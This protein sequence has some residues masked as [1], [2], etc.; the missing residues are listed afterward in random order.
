VKAWQ[1]GRY[2]DE[3]S[4]TRLDKQAGAYEV[5][6]FRDGK[7]ARRIRLDVAGGK[8]AATGAVMFDGKRHYMHL[9]VEV[10]DQDAGKTA[11]GSYYGGAD[12]MK[13]G[14]VDA[15]YAEMKK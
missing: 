6:L 3:A 9:P 11:A 15:L 14:S 8:V 5:Q 12:A 4:W 13:K 2:Q 10:L 1:H 7:L